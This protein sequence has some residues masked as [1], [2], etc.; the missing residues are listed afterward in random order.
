LEEEKPFEINLTKKVQKYS[1]LSFTY[2][3]TNA[4][5]LSLSFSDPSDHSDRTVKLKNDGQRHRVNIPY[6]GESLEKLLLKVTAR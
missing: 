5:K 2:K 3:T 6:Y 4:E 1:Y